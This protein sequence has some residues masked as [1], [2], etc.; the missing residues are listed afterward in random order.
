LGT[1][2]SVLQ[3]SDGASLLETTGIMANK[4][5]VAGKAKILVGT[6]DSGPSPAAE[7]GEDVPRV[8]RALPE[9]HAADTTEADPAPPNVVMDDVGDVRVFLLPAEGADDPPTPLDLVFLGDA[10]SVVSHDLTLESAGST[11]SAAAP[12]P[13]PADPRKLPRRGDRGERPSP[14]APPA[15]AAAARELFDDIFEGLQD[16]IACGPCGEDAFGGGGG[17]DDDHA[18]CPTVSCGGSRHESDDDDVAPRALARTAHRRRSARSPW[19]DIERGYAASDFSAARGGEAG[20]GPV[21]RARSR[22]PK[23]RLSCAAGHQK[24]FKGQV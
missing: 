21:A 17:D 16:V 20:E 8:H 5:E 6:A 3:L 10:A 18:T 2:D 15:A 9:G 7:D 13:G 14:A 12:G 4:E 23:S 24:L 1:N 22:W 19:D 11:A